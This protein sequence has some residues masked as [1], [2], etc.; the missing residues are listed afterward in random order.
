M[1]R[2]RKLRAATPE[3]F[4]RP[5][6]DTEKRTLIQSK[7][8]PISLAQHSFCSAVFSPALAV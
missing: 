6:I 3:R 5:Q 2:I 7:W 8:L 1:V 4:R